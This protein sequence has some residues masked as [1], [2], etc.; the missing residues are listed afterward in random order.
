M[1]TRARSRELIDFSD[2]QIMQ[3]VVRR[4]EEGDFDGSL[5]SGSMPSSGVA[6]ARGRLTRV[7]ETLA[8]RRI[9]AF[10]T[11]DGGLNSF[12]GRVWDI[13]LR[14]S[15]GPEDGFTLMAFFD[16]ETAARLLASRCGKDGILATDAVRYSLTITEEE[17][18][19]T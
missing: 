16:S 17:R 14:S 19:S 8:R 7:S 13:S 9:G 18:R 11:L 1:T 12:Q 6:G 10:T 2:R 5:E 15:G 3:E 4:L